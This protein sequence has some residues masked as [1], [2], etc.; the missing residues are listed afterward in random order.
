MA[1]ETATG[2][3][4]LSAVMREG[5]QVTPL[6]LFFDLVFVL[7]ITQCTQLMSNHPTWGGLAK[8]LLVLGILW[9]SWVGYAWL[10]SVVDPEEGAVRGVMFAAMAG[11]L[12]AA[13]CVPKAFGHLGRRRR[14]P[15]RRVVPARRRAGRLVGSGA[16]PRHG[17]ALLLRRRGLEADA[18]PLRRAPRPNPDNRPRRVDRRDR[19]GRGGSPQLHRGDRRGHRGRARCRDVVALLRRGSPGGREAAR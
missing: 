7:A 11:L 5:E 16:R 19:R 18:D 6:E 10:T 8:G 17:R 15:R 1:N 13:L 4:R 12:V 14:N 3:R 9:W 2:R